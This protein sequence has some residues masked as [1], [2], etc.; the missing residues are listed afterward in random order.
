VVEATRRFFFLTFLCLTL[1]LTGFAAEAART[2]VNTPGA[3]SADLRFSQDFGHPPSDLLEAGG[4]LV[5]KDQ[6]DQWHRLASDVDRKKYILR[7]LLESTGQ[8]TR[9]WTVA[10]GET[11]V[12][13]DEKANPNPQAA[14]QNVEPERS[15][16]K[17]PP[18]IQMFEGREDELVL[19]LAVGLGIFTVGWICGGN[20]Y[21]RRD[22]IKRTRLR[23]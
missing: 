10:A 6:A 2:T 8:E 13:P 16:G 7:T 22:R 14:A 21:R 12:E 9:V 5:A 11:T 15:R 3:V 17:S 1:L 23:F 19:W 20:Y 18:L 4:V